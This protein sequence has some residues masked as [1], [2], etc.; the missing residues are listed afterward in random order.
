[1]LRLERA[2]RKLSCLVFFRQCPETKQ[3]FTTRDPNQ[4]WS[5]EGRR[6]C[7]QRE[8]EKKAVLWQRY[9]DRPEVRAKRKEQD[10]MRNGTERRKASQRTWREAKKSS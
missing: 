10:R 3:Y 5:D 7:E 2:A 1:M 8:K 9:K 4:R 6:I